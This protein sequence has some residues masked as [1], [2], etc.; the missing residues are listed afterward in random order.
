M[1]KKENLVFI[2]PND[3]VSFP[4]RSYWR[5]FLVVLSV[6]SVPIVGYLLFVDWSTENIFLMIGLI[7]Q[8]LMVLLC[9]FS[10][11]EKIELSPKSIRSAVVGHSVG[12]EL[13][14]FS[15]GIVILPF[16]L[17]FSGE[18]DLSS[19]KTSLFSYTFVSLVSFA[20]YLIGAMVL[21]NINYGSVKAMKENETKYADLSDYLE[22]DIREGLYLLSSESYRLLNVTVRDAG[23]LSDRMVYE[24]IEIG[25]AYLSLDRMGYNYQ[26]SCNELINLVKKTTKELRLEVERNNEE[27]RS[28]A[29]ESNE[30]VVSLLKDKLN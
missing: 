23:F 25:E 18:G 7:V 6:I 19:M 10:V 4:M 17:L 5:I 26:E 27:K 11:T 20:L 28:C 24:L 12:F 13:F 1:A 8:A 3:K 22:Q 9:S 21:I 30:A 29:T 15:I 2:G 16:G 14:S